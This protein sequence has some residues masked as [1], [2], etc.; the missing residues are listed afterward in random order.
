MTEKKQILI[1]DDEP[2]LRR[3]LSA[4]LT[5]DGYDVHAVE[6]GQKALEALSDHHID[7]IISDLRMPRV[8][9][10]SLLK[11]VQESHPDIPVIMITAHGTVDTAV[12]ALKLGAYDFVTKPFDKDE[13]RN[14]VAKAART[15]EL[16][17]H[18]FAGEAGRYD[19]IGQSTAMQEVY[20]IIEKVADT[21]ST[22]L[23]TGESG[24]GKE[25]IARAIH[26]NG[27]RNDQGLRHARTCAAIPRQ[28]A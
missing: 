14:V 8:D 22:V 13:F 4:Q 16:S 19:I 12:E 7:V 2:N 18:E 10:L 23:I 20:Q 28:S 9:G 26:E 5:R 3:V 27:P 11:Q 25:L 24:T 21:P 6:D 17:G 15:R 1:A